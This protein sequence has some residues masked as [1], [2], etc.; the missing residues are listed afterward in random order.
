MPSP[1]ESTAYGEI[2]IYFPVQIMLI[3]VVINLYLG[4]FAGR[5]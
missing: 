2:G 5:I 3:S 1:F 4:L